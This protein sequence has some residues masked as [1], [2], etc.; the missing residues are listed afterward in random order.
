[1]DQAPQGHCAYVSWRRLLLPARPSSEGPAPPNGVNRLANPHQFCFLGNDN[2]PC[3]ILQLFT[4]RSPLSNGSAASGTQIEQLSQMQLAKYRQICWRETDCLLARYAISQYL[5]EVTLLI[6][7]VGNS[8]LQTAKRT[9]IAAGLI[10]SPAAEELTKA[11][12][13][14]AATGKISC[15]AGAFSVT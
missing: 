8:S 7:S 10:K 14:D 13:G 6:L 3:K 12:S 11:G 4:N 15:P 1:M 2:A 9:L 5:P